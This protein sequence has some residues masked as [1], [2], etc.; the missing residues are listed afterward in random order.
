MQ[1]K[2]LALS[3]LGV[4]AMSVAAVAAGVRPAHVGKILPAAVQGAVAPA[5]PPSQPRPAPVYS[6]VPPAVST[7][8]AR[9][10]SLRQTDSLPFSSYASFLMSH[11]GWPGEIAM[12]RTA[13]KA[14]SDG[15]AAYEVIGS[16]A[17]SRR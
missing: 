16:S 15:G 7:A 13:E 1:K 17:L 9:W 6:P 4:S 3:L 11:R 14:N 10:N 8:L 2:A 12:R 5:P